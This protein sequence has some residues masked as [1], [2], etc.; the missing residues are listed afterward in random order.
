MSL[1]KTLAVVIV[2]FRTPDFTLGCLASLEPEIRA[3]PGVEVYLV[4]NAS[5]DDSAERIQAGIAAHAWGD[6]VHFLQS[7]RNLGFAGGN[8]LALRLILDRP[9]APPGVLLLNSDTLVL[10]GCLQASLDALAARPR[11][12]LLS[13][14][15]C[16]RDGSPRNAVH[17]FPHPLRETCRALGLP[18]R[19]PR[20]FGWANLEYTDWDRTVEAREVEWVAG[21]FMLVRTEVLRQVGLLSEAF[22]FYGEDTEFCHRIRRGGWRV[23]HDPAGRTVHFGGGSSGSKAMLDRRRQALAWIGRLKVQ[24]LCYGR[25]AAAWVRG[26]YW[27]AYGVRVLAGVLSGRGGSEQHRVNRT[28]FSLLGTDLER[29]ARL[30]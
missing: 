14:L 10:P 28:Q 25:L 7:E 22:F 16:N 1:E 23:F 19:W 26:L 21:A 30:D 20:W 9:D 6:W 3:V 12:G 27:C 17:K 15:L 13:C 4:D 11:V 18:W 2:N 29:A 24:R 8:N 5:G